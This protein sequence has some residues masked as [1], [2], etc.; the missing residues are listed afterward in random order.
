MKL[1]K[2]L[3]PPTSMLLGSPVR[4]GDTN[5][6]KIPEGEMNTGASNWEQSREPVLK[7]IQKGER[8]TWFK[9]DMHV[10][11]CPAVSLLFGAL[12]A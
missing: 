2:A 6:A 7:A 1:A 5:A 11:L 9:A 12:S 8:S 10:A 4:M 3:P